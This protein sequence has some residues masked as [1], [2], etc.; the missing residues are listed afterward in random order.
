MAYEIVGTHST[1][2]TG[3]LKGFEGTFVVMFIAFLAV[4]V[5]LTLVAQDW[6]AFLPGAEGA[7]SMLD[8]V[9]RAVYTV[10]SQLN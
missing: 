4:T 1:H 10:I 8:G 7:K 9:K 3:S 5:A 2:R 6:R